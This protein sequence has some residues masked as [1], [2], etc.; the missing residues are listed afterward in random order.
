M[1]RPPA[2]EAKL[3]FEAAILFFFRYLAHIKLRALGCGGIDLGTSIVGDHG[4]IKCSFVSSAACECRMVEKSPYAVKFTSFFFQGVKRVRGWC[5]RH[6]FL[7]ECRGDSLSK[8]VHHGFF[9][10]TGSFGTCRPFWVPFVEWS[11]PHS[12]GVH[13]I[14]SFQCRIRWDEVL[15]KIILEC[16][17]GSKTW[18]WLS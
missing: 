11:V 2:I 12:V 9:V 5:N 14:C 3:L 6:E 13:V 7:M 15:C 18:D 10:G 1:V 8:G 16:C 17:P 4:S